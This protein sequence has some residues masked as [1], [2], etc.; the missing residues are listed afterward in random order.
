MLWIFSQILGSSPRPLA[1]TPE[2]TLWPVPASELG[3]R[4][5]NDLQ[6]E[7]VTLLAK[8][9]DVPLPPLNDTRAAKDFLR[10]LSGLNEV[11]SYARD[12][13][14]RKAKCGPAQF[15]VFR[16]LER[17]VG[18]APYSWRRFRSVMCAL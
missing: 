16:E 10:S 15:K 11:E 9:Y 13:T 4:P 18:H 5:L 14:I 3:P 17:G 2:L 12:W 8:K 6:R 7:L 1:D